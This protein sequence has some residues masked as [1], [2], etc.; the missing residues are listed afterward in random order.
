MTI[1]Y[2]MLKHSVA[3]FFNTLNMLMHG[4]LP[5]FGC[6]SVIVEEQ[7]SFL[8]VER[9]HGELV[10]PGGFT[11]WG[12]HPIQTAQ[13]EGREETGFELQ[14]GDAI[15]YYSVVSDAI[16][17]MSTLNITYVASIK[18]GDIHHSIEGYARWCDEK[19]LRARMNAYHISMLEDYLRYK[20]TRL[21]RTTNS[22][23]SVGT[24]FSASS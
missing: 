2:T 1:L 19:T 7:G 13:R 16:Y 14:I 17:H 20:A 24:S 15:G 4:N 18:H 10:F 8:V 23:P 5:A 3:F 12:E 9:P 11:R 6:A 21:P 22:A